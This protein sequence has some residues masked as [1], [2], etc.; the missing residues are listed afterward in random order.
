MTPFCNYFKLGILSG[1]LRDYELEEDLLK[2]IRR[3]PNM[4][5]IFLAFPGYEVNFKQKIKK[6][7]NFEFWNLEKI[8]QK[9]FI[10][11]I[12]R[13]IRP[14]SK[15]LF[16]YQRR[17]NLYTLFNDYAINKIVLDDFP[18]GKSVIKDTQGI[19][20]RKN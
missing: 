3:K 4:R 14:I 16:H 17:E 18:I 9:D 13:K 8:K 20:I 19:I 7:N 6:I 11:P 15:K 1:R 2:L 12:R 5:K 10:K